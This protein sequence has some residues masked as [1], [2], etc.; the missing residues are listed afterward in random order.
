[1]SSITYPSANELLPSE[2]S[3]GATVTPREI[4]N[5]VAI[6]PLTDNST[7]ELSSNEIS[8]VID[9][10]CFKQNSGTIGTYADFSQCKEIGEID[11]NSKDK[12]CIEK[13]R[14]KI[15]IVNNYTIEQID[16]KCKQCKSRLCDMNIICHICD[17]SIYLPQICLHCIKNTHV[18]CTHECWINVCKFDFLYNMAH[19]YCFRYDSSK[20]VHIVCN[21]IVGLFYDIL[22]FAKYYDFIMKKNIRSEE[23]EKYRNDSVF[24][25]LFKDIDMYKFEYKKYPIID[26]YKKIKKIKKQVI[27]TTHYNCVI[28]RC[29]DCLPINKVRMV[30]GNEIYIYIV[31]DFIPIVPLLRSAHYHEAF[32]CKYCVYQY[33]KYVN[34]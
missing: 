27:I 34:K 20:N 13:I 1:M 33:I 10:Y 26:L 18:S 30:K 31:K 29:I 4:S 24:N 19:G 9:P 3:N 28:N 14:S 8:G 32:P 21:K 17:E 5:E 23:L 25:T 22:T 6:V 2:N 7:P 16:Q 11:E 12:I 15:S